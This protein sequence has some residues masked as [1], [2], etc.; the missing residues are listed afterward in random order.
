VR[1]VGDIVLLGLLISTRGNN[2]RLLPPL[3]FDESLADEI[4]RVLDQAMDK[5]LLN[6]LGKKGRLIKEVLRTKIWP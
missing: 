1:K 5:K 2:I 3:I 6:E 4:V